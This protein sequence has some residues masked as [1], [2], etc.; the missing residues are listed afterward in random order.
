[1]PFASRNVG[2][3][4]SN[5]VSATGRSRPTICK[6]NTFDQNHLRL[7]G[8]MAHFARFAILFAIQPLPGSLHR[9]ELKD[10]DALWSPIPFEHFSSTATHDVFSAIFLHGRAGEFLVFLISGRIENIDLT[11]T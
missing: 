7:C 1:M 4:P 2:S 10:N 6:S 9:F 8:A 3:N 11:I 5:F